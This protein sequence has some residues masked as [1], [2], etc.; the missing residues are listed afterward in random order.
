MSFELSL[1]D[2][3]RG[4]SQELMVRL[5]RHPSETL[6][7]VWLRVLA[8]AWCWEERLGFSA[9]GVSDPDE[10]D[11]IEQDYTGAIVQCVLV[12]KPDTKRIQRC[13]D[14]HGKARVRVLFESEA[15]A[16]E[17]L[18]QVPEQQRERFRRA[19]L[20]ATGPGL[21]DQLASLDERRTRASITLVGDHFY[22]E[23]SGETYEGA[24]VLL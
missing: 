3:E 19:E 10:P 13:V 12:G 9:G 20:A 8:Y 4:V 16:R 23:R 15:R 5:A 17:T 1:N 11:L 18:A 6:E 2:V 21:V 24:L 7:R 22:V 14:K